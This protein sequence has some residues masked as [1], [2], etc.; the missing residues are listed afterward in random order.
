MAAGFP[1]PA[2]NY[3]DKTLDLDEFLLQNQQATFIVE[4]ESLSMRDAGID[5]KDK[6]IVDLNVVFLL[7]KMS[8]FCYFEKE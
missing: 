4:V 3:I 1:S 5:L 8:Y 7:D 6:L 2:Q